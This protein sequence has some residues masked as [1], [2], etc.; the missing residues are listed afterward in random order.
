MAEAGRTWVGSDAW[1]GNGSHTPSGR[2]MSRTTDCWRTARRPYTRR[3]VRRR[4]AAASSV[5]HKEM[6]NFARKYI[7]PY[8]TFFGE[9][10]GAELLLTSDARNLG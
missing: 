6:V 4:S 2:A 10:F 8:A 5:W 3:P 7:R 9:T 1:S